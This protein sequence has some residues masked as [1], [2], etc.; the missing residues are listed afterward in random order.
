M[1]FLTSL[2]LVPVMAPAKVVLVLALPT[3]KVR[4]PSATVP[5]LPARLE[6]ARFQPPRSRVPPLTV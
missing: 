4:E 6:A 1:P 3:L 2:P 5:P